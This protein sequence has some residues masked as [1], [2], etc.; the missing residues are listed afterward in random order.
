[1]HCCSTTRMGC[2]LLVGLL[3]TIFVNIR[4]MRLSGSVIGLVLGRALL[5]DLLVLV[6][7]NIFVSGLFVIFFGNACCR[8]GT[9]LHAFVLAGLSAVKCLHIGLVLA[10]AISFTFFIL[11]S[12]TGFHLSSHV[13]SISNS[14]ESSNAGGSSLQ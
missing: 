14:S 3:F 7:L 11:W 4:V 6:L 5:V 10:C 8:V 1:M 9:L 13:S 12:T 2:T